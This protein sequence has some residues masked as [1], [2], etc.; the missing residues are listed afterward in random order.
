MDEL[1]NDEMIKT[2]RNTGFFFAQL[3]ASN[4]PEELACLLTRDYFNYNLS[5][6]DDDDEDSIR[7]QNPLFPSEFVTV[8]RRRE[9]PGLDELI[10]TGR[11]D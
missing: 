10:Q 4:I 6:D 3:K 8:T 7:V 11:I 9:F 1:T 5:Q 2:A